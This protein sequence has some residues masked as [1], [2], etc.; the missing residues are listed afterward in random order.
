[1]SDYQSLS[2]I[3]LLSSLEQQLENLEK[4]IAKDEIEKEII[5]SIESKFNSLHQSLDEKY[6][7]FVNSIMTSFE[8]NQKLIVSNEAKPKL[9]QTH[10]NKKS[11][12]IIEEVVSEE[13]KIY[14][15]NY[16]NVITSI[17]EILDR[18][19]VV[20]ESSNIFNSLDGISIIKN[21]FSFK[22]SN[23][24]RK[25]LSNSDIFDIKWDEKHRNKEALH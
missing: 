10:A 7:D 3:E 1:M 2:S 14:N 15:K 8:N 13:D 25:L 23:K 11:K 21:G 12:S 18:I 17:D 20:T 6:N 16:Q 5:S 4:H 24:L 9:N 22:L 19:S